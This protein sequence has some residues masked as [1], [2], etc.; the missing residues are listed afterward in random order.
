MRGDNVT[1]R[2]PP[3]DI[4]GLV[5]QALALRSVGR[6]D[7]AIACCEVACRA[8]DA[9]DDLVLLSH[10]MIMQR[11][12]PEQAIAY[13]EEEAERRPDSVAMTKALAIALS[14]MERVEEAL[15][16]FQRVLGEDPSNLETA[17]RAADLA[18][19]CGD[20]DSAAAMIEWTAASLPDPKPAL[21]QG[22]VLFAESQQKDGA[23]KLLQSAEAI[24]PL[25]GDERHI[26]AAV[27]GDA[28]SVYTPA[29]VTAQFDRHAETF[30]ANLDGLRYA[31]PEIME[32]ALAES[33]L[34]QK[35]G[36]DVVDAGCG[37]GLCGPVVRPVA[38]ALTGIDL[39]PKML[40]AAE[41]RSCYDRLIAGDIK[42]IADTHAGAFDLLISADVLSYFG[43][44]GDVLR[45]F[46]R[47]LRKGGAAIVIVE[48]GMDEPLDE[49]FELQPSGR[50]RH[51]SKYLLAGM[52]AAGFSLSNPEICGIL[53]F[54]YN[55]PVHCTA[56]VGTV[57]AE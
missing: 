23:L 4:D 46:R 41:A 2:E 51:S 27:R 44:L 31:G 26:A 7:E 9:R 57:C 43:D 45:S 11:D 39:S 28:E 47:S 53:R 49:G 30:D 50:Y 14:E 35:R 21:V 1:L 34:D 52:R 8:D 40:E 20:N 16:L 48:T 18:L 55:R 32:R 25:S 5:V 17:I 6:L 54:Q 36:L 19:R 56:L 12:G 29:E 24:G 38:G 3:V 13:L 22:A 10:E 42:D 37:T 15:S 33:G